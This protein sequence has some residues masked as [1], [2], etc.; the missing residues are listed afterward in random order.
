MRALLTVRLCVHCRQRPAGFWVSRN[1]DRVVRRPWC[2]AC[3][4]QLGRAHRGITPFD[5]GQPRATGPVVIR[6]LT[7]RRLRMSWRDARR[8]P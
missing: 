7:Q 8:T 5:G 1:S 4:K 6:G 3:C 2:L